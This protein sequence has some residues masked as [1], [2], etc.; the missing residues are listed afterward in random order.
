MEN[1]VYWDNYY[2]NLKP[3]VLIPSQF[4]VFV[5]NE[6]KN[7]DHI[8]EFG[9]GNGRDTSFFSRIGL[10]VLAIDSSEFAIKLAKEHSLEDYASFLCKDILSLQENDFK[11]L[12]S[13][14][15]P[16]LCYARF[17]LHSISSEVE[18]YL[19]KLLSTIC[20]KDS[21]LALEF[22]T[23][24]DL[25]LQKETDTHFRR[26]ISPIK[27]I[28]TLNSYSFEPYYFVE[29]LGYAKHKKDDAYVARILAKKI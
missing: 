17:F 3:G 4:A 1:K 14:D 19:L 12:I 10:H 28:N 2:K 6:I 26:F 8:I 9:C 5:A 7:F 18:A 29:G 11:E 25:F 15:I 22:R 21:V 20:K 27:F 13:K 23:E 16:F 24:K